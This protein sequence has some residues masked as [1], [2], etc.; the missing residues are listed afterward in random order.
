MSVYERGFF[1]SHHEA[2]AYALIGLLGDEKNIKAILDTAYSYLHNPIHLTDLTGKL[3][4]SSCHD[5]PVDDIWERIEKNGYIDY[6][7]YQT[8]CRSNVQKIRGSISPFIIPNAPQNATLLVCGI[9]TPRHF[10]ANL[11]VLEK[12]QPIKEDHKSL[13]ALTATALSSVLD[14]RYPD[15]GPKIHACDY[16]VCD[17]LSRSN[18]DTSELKERCRIVSFFP[19]PPLQ[20]LTVC[21]S[22]NITAVPVLNM[23]RAWLEKTFFPCKT[24]IHNNRTV[25]VLTGESKREGTLDSILSPILKKYSLTA[26]L[27]RP[28]DHLKDIY[29]HYMETVYALEYGSIVNPSALFYN[30]EDYMVYRYLEEI[31]SRQDISHPCIRRL[32]EHDTKHGTDYTRTLYAYMTH[33][34]SIHDA[35]A[36]MH[37]HYNTLKYR[38]SRIRELMDLSPEEPGTFLMLYLSFKSMELDGAVFKEKR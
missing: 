27:S 34:C 21:N 11:I 7:T 16:L 12:E 19:K 32:Q 30:Y 5:F 13:L 9:Q 26:S 28:F 4:A 20:I 31:R 36:S 22:K 14:S 18:V 6:E 8:T 17:L 35:A 24:V 23:T 3:L 1:M 2:L 38:L 37:V 25:T 10:R 15:S 29:A 33:L